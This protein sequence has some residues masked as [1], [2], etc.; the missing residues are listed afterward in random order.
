VA[1]IVTIDRSVGYDV[2]STLASGG[3]VGRLPTT[4]IAR[5]WNAI[6]AVNGDF[7]QPDGQPAHEFATGGRLL[8]APGLIEDQ[9]GL[10]MR[11]P[12]TYV[13]TP[14]I[15]TIAKVEETGAQTSIDHFNDVGDPGPDQ[16][17]M[18][19]PEGARAFTPPAG[20]CYARLKPTA[21]PFL[22]T[23][24]DASQMHLV[25]STSCDPAPATIG[26]DDIFVA[27]SDGSRA[28]YLKAIKPG[29]HVKIEWTLNPQWPNV[30]D[31][32]GSNTTLVHAGA[33]SDDVVIADGPFY[34]TVGPR[35]AVGQLADGRIVLVTLD[36]RKRGYSVGMTPFDFASFLTSIGVV[37]ATNLDGGG[38]TTL[39]VNGLLV[40][41]PSDPGGE[42]AVGT[43]LVVVPAGTPDPVPFGPTASAPAPSPNALVL[44][45]DGA[46]LG[47]YAASLRA[48]GVPLPAAFDHAARVFEASRTAPSAP[49]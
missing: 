49:N 9:V 44:E 8:R 37:E 43:A 36:G 13:G 18:Y 46:S 34:A 30:L 25:A 26:S 12:K 27:K 28:A 29:Q 48:R 16:T 33:P 22:E 14:Q 10:D 17:A 23:N 40:N 3:L 32:T 6:V 20:A 31:S 1:R 2:R 24:G 19:T 7:F 5:R 11:K 41:R 45:T 4:E 38:S 21:A 47:G 15:I 35:T 39:T 42:R